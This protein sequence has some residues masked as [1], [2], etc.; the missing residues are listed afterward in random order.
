MIYPVNLVLL[1]PAISITPL[2]FCRISENLKLLIHKIIGRSVAALTVLFV[3]FALALFVSQYWLPWVLPPTLRMVGVAIESMHRTDEGCIVIDKLSYSSEAIAL[4]SRKVVLPN[5]YHYFSALLI[6]KEWDAVSIIEIETLDVSIR[7]SALQEKDTQ[8]IAPVFPADRI[9][10]FRS[11]HSSFYRMMPPVSIKTLG[12]S[13]DDFEL[14]LRDVDMS[15]ARFSAILE[16]NL[17]SEP[18]ALQATLAPDSDWTLHAAMNEAALI[19]GISMEEKTDGFLFSGQLRQP[20]EIIELT[21]ELKSG[22]SLPSIFRMES[23]AFTLDTSLFSFWPNWI[24]GLIEF[25]SIQVNW[26][27]GAGTGI[28]K[29]SSELHGFDGGSIPL[30]ASLEAGGDLTAMTFE[31]LMRPNLE[32]DSAIV[33]NGSIDLLAQALKLDYEIKLADEYL[34][35]VLEMSVFSD[36]LW[37][38]G[39]AEGPWLSPEL[40]FEVLEA[41][42][43]IPELKTVRV[44]GTGSVKNLNSFRWN[45]LAESEGASFFSEISGQMNA[46]LIHLEMLN[47]VL[48]DPQ[49]AEL[50][51]REPFSIDFDLSEGRVSDRLSISAFELSGAEE[52]LSGAYSP[53]TGVF[54][55]VSNV[56]GA[57]LNHWL[58]EPLL[59]CELE[60]LTARIT[61][62]DPFPEGELEISLLELDLRNS[63]SNNNVP[64]IDSIQLQVVA[65]SEHLEI[66]SGRVLL[67]ESELEGSMRLPVD[68]LKD[69]LH[70]DVREA[71]DL[72]KTL[73]GELNIKDWKMENWVE[74]LPAG[75]FRRSGSLN[76]SLKISEG[77]D[78][79]GTIQFQDFALRPT[80]Y[81]SSVEQISG[82]L[83]LANKRLELQSTSASVGGSRFEAAGWV[84]FQDNEAILWN[85]QILGENIPI[86]RTTDMILRSDINLEA[87]HLEQ[88]GKPLVQGRLDL[89]ASTL[90]IE[91]DPLAANTESSASLRPPFFSIEQ[92][93][94]RDWLFDVTIFGDSFMRVRSPYFRTQLSAD[95]H[96]GGSFKE[97]ELFGSV[98]TTEGRL[99]FPGMRMQINRGEAFIMPSEPNTIQLDFTGMAQSASHVITM[100]VSNTIDEPHIQLNS[101]PELPNVEIMRLL[102]TGTR[103]ES[104]AAAIGLFLGKGFLGAGSMNETLMDQL[105]I[106]VSKRQSRSGFQTFSVRFDLNEDWSLRGEYDQFDAYNVDLIWNLLRR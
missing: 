51:L 29:L 79:N 62:F 76:G 9:H 47:L 74:W 37:V 27:A 10:D 6:R 89:Q 4:T 98:R 66:A 92:E 33:F 91:F 105:T 20:E 43:A 35:S 82:N 100:E 25:Q 87:L 19:F 46:G 2:R 80:G 99:S 86:L 84:D 15:D 17:L 102:A 75:L 60:S 65:G 11:L 94:I 58:C 36:R 41:T 8:E 70:S 77:F 48:Y 18:I 23:S 50:E 7:Q 16:S 71:R 73:R 72:L 57:R 24:E 93:P 3:G 81:L 1:S 45:G 13:G 61:A 21:V 63:F 28:F 59:S 34:R 55:E 106:D 97:P 96:L 67:N 64:V 69:W 38:K 14:K 26:N 49:F 39:N 42:L 30:E 95:L 53:E 22:E 85:I 54:L 83:L 32:N 68:R 103:D 88:D 78:L 52:Q 90:L 104:G 12:I 101:T 44:Q 31:L 5:L 40:N 56:S